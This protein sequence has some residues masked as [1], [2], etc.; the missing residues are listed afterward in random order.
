VWN[1]SSSRTPIAAFQIP[2]HGPPEVE[3]ANERFRAVADQYAETKLKLLELEQAI[4]DQRAAAILASAE[5]LAE[6]KTPKADDSVAKLEAE[7][8]KLE[9]RLAELQAAVELSGNRLA[10]SI[11]AHRESW[12]RGL[13]PAKDEAAE[14]LRAALAEAKGA[15]RD[16]TAASAA[17]EWLTD[18]DLGHAHAGQQV[19][20]AGGRAGVSLRPSM[21]VNADT[22]PSELLDVVGTLLEAPKSRTSTLTAEESAR[23]VSA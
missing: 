19:Q 20:F 4:V 22:N 15:L 5:A 23:F 17:V 14:R 1:R 3:Q 9:R 16:F 7:K 13:G 11:D 10:D 2:P 8:V 6:G 18:F 12:L 21:S